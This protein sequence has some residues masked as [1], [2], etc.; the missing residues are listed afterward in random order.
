LHLYIDVCRKSITKKALRRGASHAGKRT[1]LQPQLAPFKQLDAKSLVRRISGSAV[2]HEGL[3]SPAGWNQNHLFM[4]QFLH[5][6]GYLTRKNQVFV[7]EFPAKSAISKRTAADFSQAIL[8]PK[9]S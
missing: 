4:L 1:F 9:G 3:A 8:Q 6:L 2:T 7:A 5:K